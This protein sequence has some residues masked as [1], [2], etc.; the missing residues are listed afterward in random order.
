MKKQK[1]QGQKGKKKKESNRNKGLDSITCNICKIVFTDQESKTFYC[2][3]YKL[4]FCTIW[5]NVMDACPK[6]LSSKDAED[7]S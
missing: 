4:W 7:V 3:T 6:F 2:D 1:K 5:T